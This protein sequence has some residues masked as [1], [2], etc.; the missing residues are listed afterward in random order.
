MTN[1]P[2]GPLGGLTCDEVR[3]LAAPFVLGALEADEADAVRAHLAACPDAHAEMAELAGTLPALDASVQQVDPP[4]ALR[5]R[6]MTAAA[7]DSATEAGSPVQTSV[8]PV[9]IED[10]RRSRRGVSWI[11]AV[12]AGIALVVLA[13]WN[14]L[15][16]G[17]LDQSRAYADGVA[18]VLR[19]AAQPGSLTA[20]LAPQSPA[21]AS[22]LAS[23]SADGSMTMAVR[24]LSPTTGTEVYTAWVIGTDG[25]PVSLGDLRPNGDGSAT[26]TAS[27]LPSEP[28]MVL[29]ITLEPQTG[30]KAPAGP[31]VSGGAAAPTGGA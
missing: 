30:N 26:Y 23:V 4:A 21:T 14:V 19:V 11:A 2:S 10:H 20:L 27:G 12:A 13:G 7:A 3:D 28:G 1:E 17:Q 29:A 24:S 6:I 9:A 5:D 18:A 25:V 8:E 16:Q 31:V 22:G 15:L